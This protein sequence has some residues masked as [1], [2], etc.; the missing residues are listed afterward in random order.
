MT[1]FTTYYAALEADKAWSAELSR[2]FGKRAG[3]VRYTKQGEGEAGSALNTLYLNFRAKNDIWLAQ[4]KTPNTIAAVLA[5]RQPQKLNVR[6]DS[7]EI[8]SFATEES[9][10]EFIARAQRCGKKAAI[11]L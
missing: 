5:D 1:N 11:L 9:R 6:L 4:M 7:G 2:L 3:D 10:N 8:L